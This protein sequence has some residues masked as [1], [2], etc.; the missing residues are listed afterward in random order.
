MHHFTGVVQRLCGIF[1]A[2]LT[3]QLRKLGLRE[4]YKGQCNISIPEI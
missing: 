3:V 2:I 1:F 4:V